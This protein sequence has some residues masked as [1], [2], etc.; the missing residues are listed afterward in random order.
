M[1]TKNKATQTAAASYAE[2]QAEA[3]D[4]LMRIEEQL[5]AHKAKQEKS[6]LSWGH[7]GSL[8]D[9]NEQLAYI[10]AHLGDRSAVDAKGLNY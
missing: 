8:A 10:L 5:D 2:K 1:T 4:L 3:G 7:A 6:P 9:V